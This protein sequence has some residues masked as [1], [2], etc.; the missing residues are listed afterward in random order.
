MVLNINS[1]ILLDNKDL[2]K[3]ISWPTVFMGVA[4][5]R[6][7]SPSSPNPFSQI[8]EKE[9]QILTPLAQFWERGWG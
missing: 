9:D 2:N 5:L 1:L 6:Y 4:D 8:W 3:L 7:K